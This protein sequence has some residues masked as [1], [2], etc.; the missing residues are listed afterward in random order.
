MD[1][2]FFQTKTVRNGEEKIFFSN[3]PTTAF[4]VFNGEGD[5][6]GGLTID[7][8]EGY[9]VIIGTVKEFSI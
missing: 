2:V 6:I 3:E 1:G 4:R 7:Y 9:Y 5:G 8:F